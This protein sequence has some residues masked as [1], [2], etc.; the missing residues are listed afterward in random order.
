VTSSPERAILTP[1]LINIEGRK[2]AS[3]VHFL[4]VELVEFLAQNTSL[5]KPIHTQLLLD[6]LPK[7][8]SKWFKTGTLLQAMNWDPGRLRVNFSNCAGIQGQI[9]WGK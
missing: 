4:S 1:I 2:Q 6:K 7:Q 5:F 3:K 8:L 9:V